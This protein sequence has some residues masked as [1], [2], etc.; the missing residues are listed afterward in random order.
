LHDTGYKAGMDNI[1]YCC[2]YVQHP[3]VVV[4]KEIM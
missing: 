3:A 1:I 4:D 2:E